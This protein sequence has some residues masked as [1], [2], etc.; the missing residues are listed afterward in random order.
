MRSWKQTTNTEI[1]PLKL[2]RGTGCDS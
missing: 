1:C 2:S